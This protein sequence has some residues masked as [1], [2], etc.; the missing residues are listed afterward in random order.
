[1]DLPIL[2]EMISDLAR[3]GSHLAEDRQG[4]AEGCRCLAAQVG[5]WLSQGD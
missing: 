5:S 1:V 4:H 3:S 2:R